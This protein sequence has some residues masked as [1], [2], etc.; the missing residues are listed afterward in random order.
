MPRVAKK[1][2]SAAV[3]DTFR[4][5]DELEELIEA[6]EAP[7][8]PMEQKRQAPPEVLAPA[9]P[10]LPLI[11]E[12][13]PVILA[14]PPCQLDTAPLNSKVV[15]VRLNG[16]KRPVLMTPQGE[17]PL[18]DNDLAWKLPEGGR[19]QKDGEGQ[20]TAIQ[21]DNNRPDKPLV[22][23]TAREAIARFHQHFHG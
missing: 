3:V 1:K 12:R 17:V 10:I 8:F 9:V 7:V 13:K 23:T 2:E 21:L 18:A 22:L 14:E 5:K 16:K 15:V 20:F 11:D 4:P 6:D 19:V